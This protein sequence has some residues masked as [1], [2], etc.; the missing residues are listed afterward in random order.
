[1]QESTIAL[2]ETQLY[3]PI[4]DSAGK[5]LNTKEC[6]LILQACQF[7]S[8]AHAGI[9][10]KSGDKFVIH[11]IAVAELLISLQIDANA[12]V[13]AILH[14]VVEDTEYELGELEEI[15]GPE[16]AKLVNGVSRVSDTTITDQKAAS[17][18]KLFLAMVDDIRVVII[19]LADR[20]HNMRTIKHMPPNDR[21]RIANETLDMYAPLAH[22]LAMSAWGNELQDISL[23]VIHPLRYRV[24]REE[25]NKLILVH[26]DEIQKVSALIKQHLITHGIHA[27][28]QFRVKRLYSVYRKMIEKNLKFSEVQDLFALRIVVRDTLECYTAIGIIH[29]LFLPIHGAFK[30]YIAIPKINGYQS[31]HTI[32]QSKNQIRLEIQI[33][34]HEMHQ[35]S[36]SGIASHWIYKTESSSAIRNV[37]SAHILQYQSWFNE[38]SHLKGELDSDKEFYSEMQKDIY[39]DSIVVY[40]ADGAS[41]SLPKGS[42]ALDFAYAI[43]TSIGNSA[44]S[45]LIDHRYA[46]LSSVLEFGQTIEIQTSQYPQVRNSHLK[47]VISQKAKQAIRDY[48]KQNQG[49]VTNSETA[50][51]IFASCCHP[52]RGDRIV[53]ISKPEDEVTTEIVHRQSCP[54]IETAIKQRQPIAYPSWETIKDT[55]FTVNIEL[56]LENQRGALAKACHVISQ[57]GFDII[58]LSTDTTQEKPLLATSEILLSLHDR[59]DLAKLFRRLDK[60]S[61][62]LKTQR[63]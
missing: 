7:A 35:F 54:L 47:F 51:F 58:K 2:P 12:I 14:D 18:S 55:L 46:P 29:Q 33:R 15:F 25:F 19:K 50:L 22:R 24:L 62:V 53:S 43:S 9:Y 37:E 30:D 16:V 38:L 56:T 41:L 60:V 10:R 21:I 42:T 28:I 11:P 48:L 32:I 5:Y 61:Y 57:S 44:I 20:L 36:E 49:S 4:L 8:R 59:D 13:A 45:A 6:H 34:T 3:Q 26:D 31:L 52:I 23:Q 63:L 39:Y 27:D 40:H 17:Y 1:M